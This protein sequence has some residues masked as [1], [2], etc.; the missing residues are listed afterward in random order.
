LGTRTSSLPDAIS[1]V[2]FLSLRKEIGGRLQISDNS[3]RHHVNSIMEKLE[4]SDR[5]EAVA[6]AI[7]SGVLSGN[8]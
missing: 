2:A 6:T 7:R 8:N 1:R 5:T 4:V 3:V